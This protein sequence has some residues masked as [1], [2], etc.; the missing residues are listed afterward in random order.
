MVHALKS[1]CYFEYIFI[2][3]SRLT[4]YLYLFSIHHIFCISLLTLLFSFLKYFSSPPITCCLLY[5]AIKPY[6][7]VILKNQQFHDE[8]DME[9]STSKPVYLLF[10]QSNYYLSL[11]DLELFS[12]TTLGTASLGKP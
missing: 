5:P 9:L 1:I 4:T 3:K 12:A 7:L 10:L 8:A 2:I 11:L 6:V